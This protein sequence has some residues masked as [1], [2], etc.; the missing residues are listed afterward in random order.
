MVTLKFM[1]PVYVVVDTRDGWNGI[2]K[3]VV[4]DETTFTP[5]EAFTEDGKALH[6]AA[7][8]AAIKNGTEIASSCDWPSWQFGW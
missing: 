2:D 3:V 7:L 4:D 8:A 5:T 1:V 6:G